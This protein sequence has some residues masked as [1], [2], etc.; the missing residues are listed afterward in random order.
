MRAGQLDKLRNISSE[1]RSETG[2]VMVRISGRSRPRVEIVGSFLSGHGERSLAAEVEETVADAMEAYREQVDAI[3][4]GS[5]RED[6]AAQAAKIPREM[7]ERERLGMEAI[8]DVE[9][10]GVSSGGYATARV[11]GDGDL[12]IEFTNNPLRRKDV[13]A[14]VLTSEVNDAIDAA[15]TLFSKATGE[16]LTNLNDQ[17]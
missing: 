7:R 2:A 13:T 3:V 8:G 15:F 11:F 1:T 6:F 10:A 9:A 14:E 12:V 17:T 4:N 16:A 5:L